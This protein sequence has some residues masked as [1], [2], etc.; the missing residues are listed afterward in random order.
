MGTDLAE[1][2]STEISVIHHD[3]KFKYNR[4]YFQLS[5]DRTSALLKIQELVMSINKII[6]DLSF[7]Y[8]I[9]AQASLANL[10]ASQYIQSIKKEHNEHLLSL[11]NMKDASFINICGGLA[12]Y[13]SDID[14][15]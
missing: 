13:W 1:D 2:S 8:S 15:Q 12:K 6:D 4:F 3:A 14:D 11:K 5:M 9:V 7:L 10:S